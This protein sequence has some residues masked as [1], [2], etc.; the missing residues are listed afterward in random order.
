MTCGSSITRALARCATIELEVE[1]R[2]M[3][4]HKGTKDINVLA[5]R[6]SYDIV[7]AELGLII[8][9]NVRSFA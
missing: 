9:F 7:G 4:H 2:Q 8:N 6:V 3:I 5:D 1:L